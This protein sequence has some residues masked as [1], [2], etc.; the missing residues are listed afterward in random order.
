MMRRTAVVVAVALLSACA[1]GDED[2]GS[3]PEVTTESESPPSPSE[4]ISTTTDPAR[5]AECE[6]LIG[7]VTPDSE[8]NTDEQAAQACR[9]DGHDPIF[10]AL[11]VYAARPFYW[12]WRDTGDVPTCADI[13]GEDN[14]AGGTFSQRDV[15]DCEALAAGEDR[16]DRTGEF[17]TEI[18]DAA[19]ECDV[20]GN[21]GDEGTSIS[22]DTVGDNERNGDDI[23]DLACVLA[24][25]DVPDH[26]LNRM[27]STRALDGQVDAEW[28][29][30]QAF[31][32]YH[33][34]TGLALTIWT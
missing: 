16:P 31:W 29:D 18:S 30:Y 24:E 28:D 25:L 13:R 14:P 3:S 5:A 10:N 32:T 21:V 23:N 11:T 7:R 8:G 4:T 17:D 33:P 19:A 22:F 6:E 27:D 20:D 1:G 26:V 2:A 15:G 12:R 9:L 34:D